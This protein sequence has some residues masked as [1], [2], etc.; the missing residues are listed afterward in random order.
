MR[1]KNR[2]K[3]KKETKVKKMKIEKRK[4][5]DK[6]RIISDFWFTKTVKENER[7]YKCLVFV[8]REKKKEETR[9]L[10]NEK[11]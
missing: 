11:L 1:K 6:K 2:K 4:K 10:E 5:R 8:R 3:G 9:V 7:Y